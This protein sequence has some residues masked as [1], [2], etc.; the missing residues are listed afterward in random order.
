MKNYS[1]V[2]LD[3]LI[4]PRRALIREQECIGCT[5]CIQACPVDAIIGGPKQM[6]TVLIDA[7]I[8]CE[9]CVPS[10]PVDCIEMYMVENVTTEKQQTL[11]VHA[12]KLYMAKQER[13]QDQD[14]EQT[15][16]RHVVATNTQ[17]KY[18]QS[19]I[20]ASLERVKH[21]KSIITPKDKSS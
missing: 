5:K 18:L 6:H 11:R 3:A 19:Y 21:K 15:K 4:S 8:G 16:K 9:L 10:C 13:M 17:Q 14:S 1:A 20:R 2:E 7:C 12:Q